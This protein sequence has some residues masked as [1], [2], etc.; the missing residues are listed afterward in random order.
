M[1]LSSTRKNL[2]IAIDNVIYKKSSTCAI[3]YSHEA[4][5]RHATHFIL[6]RMC[7]HSQKGYLLMLQN[8]E[9]LMIFLPKCQWQIIRSKRI[10]KMMIEYQK[11]QREEWIL[12]SL[13]SALTA[14]IRKRCSCDTLSVMLLLFLHQTVWTIK[15][16]NHSPPFP[17]LVTCLM[18]VCVNM[19][20]IHVNGMGVSDGDDNLGSVRRY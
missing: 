10:M 3:T 17:F 12:L 19:Q 11:V 1:T 8:E 2:L 9:P 18:T 5:W 13:E 20:K 4:S 7:V 6:V 14:A 16:C 15:G